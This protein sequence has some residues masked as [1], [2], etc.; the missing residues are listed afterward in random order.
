MV[1]L[2]SSTLKG[3]EEFDVSCS[4]NDACVRHAALEVHIVFVE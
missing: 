4:E 3:I 1:F 2:K